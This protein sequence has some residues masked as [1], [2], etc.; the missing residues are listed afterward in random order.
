MLQ[1]LSFRSL[2]NVSVM[3]IAMKA[4]T[5][6]SD[7]VYLLDYAKNAKTA[8]SFTTENRIEI[9]VPKIPTIAENAWTGTLTN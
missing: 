9:V 5:A 3:V 6:I 8:N 7:Q 2:R 1:I 4:N